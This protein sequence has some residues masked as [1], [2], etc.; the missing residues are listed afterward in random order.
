VTSGVF[1]MLV[2]FGLI[3]RRRFKKFDVKMVR[4]VRYI[5]DISHSAKRKKPQRKMSKR[6]HSI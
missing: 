1:R 5:R 4:S 2:A 3:G 6:S